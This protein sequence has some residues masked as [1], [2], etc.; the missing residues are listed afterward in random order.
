M[1]QFKVSICL[2]TYN[3]PDYLRLALDSIIAQDFKDYEVIITDD[4]TNDDSVKLAEEY[5]LKIP[6]LTYYKNQPKKGSPGNWN[7]A[8]SKAK[9]EYVKVLHSDDWFTKPDSLGKFVKLLDENPKSDFG[10][11]ATNVCGPDQKFKYLHAPSAGKLKSLRKDPSYLFGKNIVGAPSATIYRK[12]IKNELYDPKLKWAVDVDQ[13]MSILEDN[14]DFA[15]SQEPLISTTDGAAHQS[16]H[17]SVGFMSVELYEWL[18][19]YGKLMDRGRFRLR[20][21][22]YIMFLLSRYK[23]KSLKDVESLHL[24]PRLLKLVGKLL[25]F[26]MFFFAFR[27]RNYLKHHA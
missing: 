10:F 16:I 24:E 12:G 8:I 9:G 5:K 4:S 13:Y 21:P 26:R 3:Q 14:P 15:Y 20:H 23:V 18:L 1:P 22:I 11:S 7:E 6:N 27:L 25:K 19:V 17:E 2:P